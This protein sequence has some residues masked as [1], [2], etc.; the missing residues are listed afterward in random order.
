MSDKKDEQK[1][2]FWLSLPGCIT[3]FGGL[4][5]AIV[6]SY[7]AL[8]VAGVIPAPF[9]PTPTSPPPILVTLPPFGLEPSSSVIP[10]NGDSVAFSPTI[11][12]SA[13]FTSPPTIT[14]TQPIPNEEYVDSS[15]VEQD[16]HVCP[17]GF[18]I[19]GVRDDRNLLLCRRVMRVGEEKFVVTVLDPATTLTVRSD[20]HACPLGM[21]MRGLRVDRNQ[22]LCSYDGRNSPPSEWQTEFLNNVGDPGSVGYDMHICP[23]LAGGITYL[24][25]IR[26][27]QNRFLCAR[28]NQ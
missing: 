21:Y 25:G 2:S 19:A 10:T 20:M 17:V 26:V 7:V 28:H 11:I 16:M 8:V 1:S 24:T 3:A 27:D 13:T 4:I 22:L 12:P 14:P 15:T 6:G 23:A 5:T 9:A 18:A